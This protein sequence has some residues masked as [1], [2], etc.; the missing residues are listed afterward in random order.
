MTRRAVTTRGMAIALLLMAVPIVPAC[1]SAPA[2]RHVET[3]VRPDEVLDFKTLYA[4]NCAGCH[5]AEGRG[6]AALGLANPIYLAIA[7]DDVI[8]DA[9]AKGIPHTPMAA[10][11]QSAGGMLTDAQVDALVSG[12]RGQWANPQA[13]QGLDPAICRRLA[14]RRRARRRALRQR[15]RR[16]PRQ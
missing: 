8:R 2:Y 6:G 12:M 5:G 14:G 10:F 9:I 15:V 11:S 1:D 4:A 13:T 3:H 7:G 16:M